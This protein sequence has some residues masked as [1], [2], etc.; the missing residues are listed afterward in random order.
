MWV[1]S[2]GWED[3]LE[4]DMATHS[5]ILAWWATVHGLQR[6]GH[7]ER[8]STQVELLPAHFFLWLA[9]FLSVLSFWYSLQRIHI[10]S[11]HP[12][13]ESDTSQFIYKC[14]SYFQVV[15]FCVTNNVPKSNLVHASW[16]THAWV[17]RVAKYKTGHSIQFEFWGKNWTLF[18]CKYAP[19]KIGIC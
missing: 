13:L 5:R 3:P 2:L 1:K 7:N 8:L 19:C 14:V 15:C 12:H 6:V 10:K 11:T 9:F 16:S 4:K 17:S 18:E